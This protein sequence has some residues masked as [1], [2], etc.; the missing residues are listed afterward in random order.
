VSKTSVRSTRFWK[1]L[2]QSYGARLSDQYGPTCP[3]DWCAV[4]D[5]ADDERLASALITIRRDHLQ[6]PPT[7]GQFEAAIPQRKLHGGD[8]VPDR[9]ALHARN[10]L[11]LC[12]HQTCASW[13]YFGK[14]GE[15]WYEPWKE[16]RKTYETHGVVIPSCS[17][18]GKSSFRVTVQDLSA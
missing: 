8:S 1:R 12:E 17:T 3:E 6:F 7:L 14:V 11:S 9:L 10:R 13:S 2:I 18:C 5:R 4:I 16:N 15:E